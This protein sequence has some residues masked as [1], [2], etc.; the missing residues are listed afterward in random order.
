MKLRYFAQFI[1]PKSSI[2]DIWQTS[3]YASGQLTCGCF[4]WCQQLFFKFILRENSTQFQNNIVRNLIAI[5]E[6]FFSFFDIK[7]Y[8]ITILEVGKVCY[9]NLVFRVLQLRKKKKN[10]ELKRQIYLL[11]RNIR[12]FFDI[13]V[14]VSLI[15]LPCLIPKLEQTS[16][17]WLFNRKW[18]YRKNW[19]LLFLLWS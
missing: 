14:L 5:F 2:L 1:F 18:G 12:F 7:C 13:A 6:L 4:C 17:S 9:Q 3:A 10:T 8:S 11:R 15:R 16:Y 19:S